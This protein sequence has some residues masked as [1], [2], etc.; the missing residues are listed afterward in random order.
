MM[1]LHKRIVLSLSLAVLVA[2]V[3]L[4]GCT[5]AKKEQGPVK[6]GVHGVLFKGM[7]I[8]EDPVTPS[9]GEQKKK[10]VAEKL[11][12]AGLL[13][14]GKVVVDEDAKMLE[15]MEHI[16]KFAGKDYVL[17]QTPPKV[18]FAVVPVEPMFLGAS[19]VASKSNI[20]NEPGPWSNWSQANF[21]TRTGKFYSSVGDHGKYDA[22]ILLV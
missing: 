14:T 10:D 20:S 8:T 6:V 2:L 17:A 22:H 16:K 7:Q 3:A 1:E 18:E 9:E 21:D 12:K 4:S 5:G 15:P 13:Y 19:P 11:D